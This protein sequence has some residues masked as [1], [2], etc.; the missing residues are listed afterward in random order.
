MKL[1][2]EMLPWMFM[3][4]RPISLA[5]ILLVRVKYLQISQ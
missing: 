3:A 2:A 5:Y 1:L 4:L